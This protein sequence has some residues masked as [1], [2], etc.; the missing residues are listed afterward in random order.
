MKTSE[1][2]LDFLIEQGFAPDVDAETGNI[3]F[4][5]QMRT[6]VFFNNDEDEEFLQ[7]AMPFIFDFTEDKRLE[8]LEAANRLSTS[9]KVIK[10]GVIR[11]NVWLFF[12]NLLDQT[13]NV[14]D[15]LPRAFNMLLGA[16]QHFYDI[17]EGKES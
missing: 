9:Y 6:F 3:S 14:G 1:Q 10:A 4:K 7:I 16:Q 12:E 11:D 17:L 2:V 8:V 5:Y 13:P 15:L